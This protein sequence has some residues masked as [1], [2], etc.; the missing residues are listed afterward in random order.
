MRPSTKDVAA[1][2]RWYRRNV[3][4]TPEFRRAEAE[5]TKAYYAAHPEKKREQWARF[6]AKHGVKRRKTARVRAAMQTVLAGGVYKPRFAMRK[7]DYVAVGESG[8]DAR[9][10]WLFENATD[11]QRAYARE[12]AI[13]RRSTR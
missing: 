1:Y 3:R 5:R 13:E 7:P 4:N 11:S 12:L 9:S 6:V 2:H 8:L 10:Q